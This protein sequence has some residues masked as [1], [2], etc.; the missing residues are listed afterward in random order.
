MSKSI[1]ALMRVS[2]REYLQQFRE[3]GLLYMN[4]AA[5][6]RFQRQMSVLIFRREA[7]KKLASVGKE[8]AFYVMLLFI[9]ETPS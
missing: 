8:Q 1:F 6:Y 2:R 4:S 7:L 9:Q 3:Q 5:R